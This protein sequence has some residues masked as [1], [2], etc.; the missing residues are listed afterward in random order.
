MI[1]YHSRL[2]VSRTFF[3]SN[4]IIFLAFSGDA[5]YDITM[6]Q[7]KKLIKKTGSK[8]A[9]AKKLEITVRYV[10]MILAGKTPS[11]RIIKLIKIYLAS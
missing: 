10:D 11:K 8:K 6:D 9:T 7:L 3:F 2:D 1:R 4:R 5:L